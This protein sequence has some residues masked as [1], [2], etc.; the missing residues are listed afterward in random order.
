VSLADTEDKSVKLA[1][2]LLSGSEEQS[3]GDCMSGTSR[4]L[5]FSSPEYTRISEWADAPVSGKDAW[6]TRE[7]DD[8]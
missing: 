5:K 8:L 7:R 6:E 3:W 4:S 1:R 2:A